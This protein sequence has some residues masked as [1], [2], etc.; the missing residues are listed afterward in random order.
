MRGQGWNRTSVFDLAGATHNNSATWHKIRPAFYGGANHL[1]GAIYKFGRTNKSAPLFSLERAQATACRCQYP[2]KSTDGS[3][4][5]A[6]DRPSGHRFSDRLRPDA[7]WCGALAFVCAV[8]CDH[9]SQMVHP[10]P[11]GLIGD[12]DP[13]FRQ[14]IFD[15]AEAQRE[16]NIEPDRVLD[17]FGREA[18]AAI[19]DCDHRGWYG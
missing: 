13:A 18:V 4:F 7:R 16:P 11:D 6:T 1:M 8:C 9:R 15:V 17:D 3:R 12:H 5:S 2:Q 10:A 14:Q 19:A